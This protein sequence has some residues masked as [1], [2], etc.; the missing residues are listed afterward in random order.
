MVQKFMDGPEFSMDVLC[1]LRGRCLNAIPRT[2]IESRGGESIKG[3]VIADDGWSTLGGVSRSLRRRSVVVLCMPGIPRT[4]RDP[5][6][7]PQPT[8]VIRRRPEQ[9]ADAIVEYR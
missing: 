6:S 8:V 3:T 4:A 7:H 2:M 5:G 9:V 1:D